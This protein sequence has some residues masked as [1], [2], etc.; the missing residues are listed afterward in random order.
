MKELKIVVPNIKINTE[1]FDKAMRQASGSIEGMARAI[2][3]RVKK[4]K[5]MKNKCGRIYAAPLGE[6]L[7]RL[8]CD[9]SCPGLGSDSCARGRPECRFFGFDDLNPGNLCGPKCSTRGCPYCKIHLFA[10]RE[11]K[12]EST[13]TW[14]YD[15]NYAHAMASESRAGMQGQGQPEKE[16]SEMAQFECI[17][18]KMPTPKEVEE[19]ETPKKIGDVLWVEAPTAGDA[20]RKVYSSE[21]YRTL[22]PDEKDRENVNVY[23]RE[24]KGE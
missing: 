12:P 13:P 15:E 7:K 14:Q 1:A 6:G 4:G 8:T 18:V 9:E 3:D 23:A 2:V 24:F 22:V 10:D 20:R 16:E 11:P 21:H 5:P 19:G 17:T